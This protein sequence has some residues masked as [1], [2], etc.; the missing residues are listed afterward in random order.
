MTK[1][2]GMTH[3]Q[4]EIHRRKRVIEDAEKIASDRDRD[5]VERGLAKDQPGVVARPR[6]TANGTTPAI[7][8][9][10]RGPRFA[11]PGS[12][13]EASCFRSPPS[14]HEGGVGYLLDFVVDSTPAK[15]RLTSDDVSIPS[16]IL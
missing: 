14:R 1:E 7:P 2:I 6:P 5:G 15:G 4:R 10:R 13:A 9:R 16:D 11:L 8:L 3:E 12:G